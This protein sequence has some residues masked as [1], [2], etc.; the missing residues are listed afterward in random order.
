MV[1]EISPSVPPF[2]PL[3]GP[4]L[5]QTS[6][7]KV[8]LIAVAITCTENIV[9]FKDQFLLHTIVKNAYHAATARIDNRA[10]KH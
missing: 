5:L 7:G 9:L 8:V 2:D 4:T 6:L 10:T 3:S 1:H